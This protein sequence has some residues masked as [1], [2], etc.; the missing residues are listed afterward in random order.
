MMN[1]LFLAPR[2]PFPIDTGG[3]IRTFNI[4]KMMA[5]ENQVHLICFS[6]DPSDQRYIR[7][8]ERWGIKV[9]LVPAKEPTLIE[10]IMGVLLNSLPFSIAKY[11]T[12]Q[13]QDAIQTIL[14]T[15]V[16]N[17]I[18]VD[19]LH[20]AHYKDYFG[21]ISCMLDEHNVEYKIL[22]RCAHVEKYFLKKI[23]YKNQ[24]IK[25]KKFES[26][27]CQEY[28]K[29]SACSLDDVI[30]LKALTNGTTL[31]YVIPN[32]VDTEY[33]DLS[34]ERNPVSEN[35]LVF[36]GSMDWLP[37]DD[38][39]TYFC[40]EILPLIWNKNRSVKL[41]VVGKSPSAA[42]KNMAAND[43]RLT[44]TGRV[45]DVRPY[46]AHA[47]IFIVP[48]RIGGGTRLKILEAMSM[49]RAIVSTTLGAEG[50]SYSKENIILADTPEA[51]AQ[52][53]CDLL[54]DPLRMMK[55]GER[56]R[57]LVAQEYDWSIVG[58]TLNAIYSEVIYAI[59]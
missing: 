53:V 27:K 15:N 54:G 55:M 33:F 47:K 17:A 58:R 12:P 21:G 5:L 46:M 30:L 38:A 22:E 4:L 25:M 34:G 40:K 35:T 31:F 36:T 28:P 23:F 37:N 2:L 52:A 10:K 3:K 18:H 32:G 56:G 39:M 50:I 26:Q 42:L 51:F 48:L 29:V 24:A 41:C 13:M 45:E 11:K 49:R 57:A 7:E 20:M 59:K 1:I 16:F 44:L 43:L 19:H 9:T 8:F 14:R 6:F